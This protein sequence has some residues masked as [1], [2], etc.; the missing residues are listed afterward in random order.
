MIMAFTMLRSAIEH[1][2]MIYEI[3]KA[4]YSGVIVLQ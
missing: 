2:K 1:L 4:V 3:Q